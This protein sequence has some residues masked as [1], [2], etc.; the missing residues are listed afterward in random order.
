[1]LP[2]ISLAAST[3]CIRSIPPLASSIQ[4]ADHPLPSGTDVYVP[5][6]DRL[7]APPAQ[8]LEARHQLSLQ[9]HG[10]LHVTHGVADEV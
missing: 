6:L 2:M 10:P 4:D 1:V 3:T 5:N 8:A 7:L 9:P